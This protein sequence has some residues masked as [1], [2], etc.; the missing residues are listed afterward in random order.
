WEW[1][2]T[3]VSDEDIAHQERFNRHV[4][5]RAIE[6]ALA[7]I[8]W[9]YG[10]D[11]KGSVLC[12][13]KSLVLN[14]VIIH[15]LE[16]V[17]VFF[18]EPIGRADYKRN[19]LGIDDDDLRTSTLHYLILLLEQEAILARP[20]HCS[21]AYAAFNET[22]FKNDKAIRRLMQSRAIYAEPPDQR[23][24]WRFDSDATQAST[25]TTEPINTTTSTAEAT[26]ANNHD[27]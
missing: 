23:G 18:Q 15:L 16:A 11:L 20:N 17:E 25:T 22:E 4:A 5:V 12:W 1:E 24:G 6:E 10:D 3:V 21:T 13:Q 9:L 14:K 26:G 7:T 8:I 27:H 2:V 19:M